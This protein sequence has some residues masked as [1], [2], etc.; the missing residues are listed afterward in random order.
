MARKRLIL[1]VDD[2][3]EW[4]LSIAEALSLHGYEAAHAI[5]GQQGIRKSVELKPDAILLDL[6]LPGDDGWQVLRMLRERSGTRRTPVV[7]VSGWKG[8]LERARELPAVA[9]LL[10]PVSLDVLLDTLRQLGVAPAP[11]AAVS[12]G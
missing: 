7:L 12:G 8:E 6:K 11:E 9:A 1:I 4:R 2:N 10:K 5:D 3:M